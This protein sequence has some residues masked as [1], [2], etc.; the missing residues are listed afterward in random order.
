MCNVIHVGQFSVALTSPDNNLDRVSAMRLRSKLVGEAVHE[1]NTAVAAALPGI[2]LPA[3][4]S[5]TWREVLGEENVIKGELYI[6]DDG[7]P[8]NA[9]SC[10][11]YSVRN[12]CTKLGHTAAFSQ[13]H[14]F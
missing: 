13:H 6:Y 4:P 2:H 11:I 14:K 10:V 12:A 9:A 3:K 7:Y 1:I 8:E 5:I